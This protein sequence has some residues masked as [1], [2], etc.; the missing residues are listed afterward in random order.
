VLPAIGSRLAGKKDLAD[1]LVGHRVGLQPPHRPHR[2]HDLED[3]R[4][5]RGSLRQFEIGADRDPH[6]C[7]FLLKFQNLAA[8]LAGVPLWC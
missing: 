6:V 8:G 2:V 3:V 1:Q 4:R 7:C 5:F